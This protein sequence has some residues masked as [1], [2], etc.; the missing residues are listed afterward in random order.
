MATSPNIENYQIPTGKAYFTA[1]GESSRRDLG[2]V[3]NFSVAAEIQKKQHI[4]SYGGKRKKDRTDIT[5]VGGTA[6][7]V[8]DE[9]TELNVSFFALGTPVDA[10]GGTWTIPALTNTLFQGLLEVE[11]DNDRGPILQWAGNVTFTPAGDFSFIKDNDDYNQIS[12]EADIEENDADEGFGTW[13]W[14]PGTA[15]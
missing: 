11:G 14:L 1:A 10:G 4:R 8:I 7:F 13:T 9:I 12:C 2:N 15:T 6:K 5:Q 3:V